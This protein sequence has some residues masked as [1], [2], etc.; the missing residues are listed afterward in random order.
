MPDGS[1]P[2]VTK[3]F[4]APNKASHTFTTAGTA[5]IQCTIHPRTM[6]QTITVQ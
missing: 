4:T 5:K 2:E 6:N 3:Q 1:K